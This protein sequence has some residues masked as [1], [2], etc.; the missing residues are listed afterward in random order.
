M[1]DLPDADPRG[2]AEMGGL[3]SLFYHKKSP[4]G[5]QIQPEAGRVDRRELLKVAQGNLPDMKE[6]CR[7]GVFAC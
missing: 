4:G 6:I 1:Q 3:P 7:E 2:G 5:L